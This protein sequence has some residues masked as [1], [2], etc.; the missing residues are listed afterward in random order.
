ML[1]GGSQDLQKNIPQ[2]DWHVG[3]MKYV[4]DLPCLPRYKW[5]AYTTVYDTAQSKGFDLNQNFLGGL[6]MTVPP[7]SLDR[8]Y[9]KF[10]QYR[11]TKTTTHELSNTITLPS[12]HRDEDKISTATKA[13]RCMQRL[14]LKF[15][16][17][18][19]NMRLEIWGNMLQSVLLVKK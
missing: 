2:S 4:P 5:M 17:F 11:I 7:I 14:P 19:S 8:S 3:I 10:T 15:F 18:F 9:P 16:H 1:D 12:V 6:R 13:Y